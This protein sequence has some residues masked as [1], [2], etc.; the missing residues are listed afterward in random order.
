MSEFICKIFECGFITHDVKYFI[1]EKPKGFE[2]I[3]GQACELSI[4]KIGLKEMRRPFTIASIPDSDFLEFIIKIY[5][6]REDGMTKHLREIKESD[7]FILSDVFGE[8]NY[9]G[10]GTFIAGGAGITPFISIFRQ[11]RKNNLI[12]GN[13]LIFS[14]KTSKDI[15]LE[16]DLKALFGDKA[17]FTLTREKNPSYINERINEDF[18]RKNIKDFSQ[19]FYI[20]GPIRFVGE[21]QYMLRKLGVDSS[22]IVVE[23]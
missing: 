7:E 17:I 10:K 14:N 19:K 13:S 3:S 1:V 16:E 23:T 6:T 2:F 11:L 21:I 18:L 5:D 9:S 20:C 15:I 8:I 4:N 22:N 12:E